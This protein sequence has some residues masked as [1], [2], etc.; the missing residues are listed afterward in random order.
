MID[1]WLLSLVYAAWLAGSTLP[2]GL[3]LGSSCS[4][5]CGCGVADG[6][7][8]T[9][10]VDEG[11]WVPSGGWDTNTVNDISGVTW[12]FQPYSES[13]PGETW[14]FWGSSAT[15][16]PAGGSASLALQRD[17]GNLCNWYSNK[18]TA[19]PNKTSL[20]TNLNKR[21]TRLPPQNAVVHILSP[22]NTTEPRR[23]KNMYVWITTFL[24]GSVIETTASAHDSLYGSVFAQ[25]TNSGEI[26]N[27]ATFVGAF[28]NFTGTVNGGAV[29]LNSADNFSIVND[30]ALFSFECQNAINGVV[31]GGATFLNGSANSGSAV[32]NGG[33]V[34]SGNALNGTGNFGSVCVVNEGAAFNDTAENRSTVNDGATFND[35]AKNRAVYDF[36][37]NLVYAGVVN[38]GATFNDAAC[39][40]RVEGNYLV[41]CDA[42][43]VAHPVDLP[44]C[45][46]TAPQAC[47]GGD[48][49]RGCG[50]G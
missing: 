13:T 14:F 17:W 6:K 15:S 46:G 20:S 37:G 1:D 32:V 30:G 43:F 48:P 12:S 25:A 9:D 33:A 3:M 44:T 47:D 36:L 4:P 2:L 10:P 23:V 28:G 38:D 19:P 26:N 39:T 27:G 7:P 31:N 35:N 24:G 8:R 50:C 42:K 18:L 16:N 45:N 21:A 29:F 11:T 34:F 5:C 22:V 49:I 41:P 40:E